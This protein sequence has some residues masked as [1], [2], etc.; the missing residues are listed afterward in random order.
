LATVSGEKVP[1]VVTFRK[2]VDPTGRTPGAIVVFRDERPIRK[3]EAEM[4]HVEKL[5]SLGTMV[6][7]IAHELNNPLTSIIGFSELGMREGLAP[8]RHEGFFRSIN[9]EAQ[10]AHLVI[11]NLLDFART[12]IEVECPVSINDVLKSI[13]GIRRLDLQATGIDLDEVYE[14]D[15]PDTVGD[16]KKIRQLLMNII[17]NAADAAGDSRHRGK[18]AVR[19]EKGE[20]R[21][22]VE[23]S[24]NG[25]GIPKPVLPKIFD[26]FFTTK[27]VGMGTGLGLS[28]SHA[29]AVELGGRID[30]ESN[31][32][33]GTRFT[34]TVPIVVPQKR[35][36]KPPSTAVFRER[37]GEKPKI[38][39]V[40]DEEVLVE[41]MENFLKFKG[42]EVDRAPDG[43]AGLSKIS[44]NAYDIILCDI[45]MPNMNGRE[46]VKQ[47][48]EKDPS[49]LE[50]IVICSGDT[51][52]PD[53]QSFLRDSGL[54]TL[55]KPF[56]LKELAATLKSVLS[57]TYYLAK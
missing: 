36:G 35:K 14:D 52:S 34:V 11:Q 56:T 39:I 37:L 13:L 3:L 57:D 32:G 16:P 12:P 25:P 20:G 22:V 30:V 19:T 21:I 40:D 9:S 42:C 18:I 27:T 54:R 55:N 51:V 5:H 49:A 47:L 38:L 29:M 31:E 8:D 28:I 50:K 45:K 10:K 48:Q 1:V 15:L 17:N 44:K 2:W 7:G 23:I 24:D 53:T 46:M 43:E 6:S 26:P 41:M 33:E 4:I